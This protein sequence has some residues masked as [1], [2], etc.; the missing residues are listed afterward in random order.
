MGGGSRCGWAPAPLCSRFQRSVLDL[1][2]Q[3]RF[4]KLPNNAKLEVVPISRNRVGT[5]NRV[6]IALQLDSGSRLQDTFR[7][8]QT[9]WELLSHFTQTRE[10]VEQHGEFSPVCIYMRDEIAGKAALE[11]TTLKSLGLTGGNAIIRVVMKKCGSSGQ[12]AAVDTAAQFSKLPVSP[13]STEGAVDMSLPH[14]SMFSKD[15]D[16][17]DVA[18]SLN[19]CTD[20][21]DLIKVSQAS[22]GELW[23][24]SDPAPAPFVPF[25][26]DG[27]RLGGTPVAADFPV[28]DMLSSKLP[29]S[30]PSPGGPS[31][32]KKSKTS[33]EQLKEQE[34]L[35]EREPVVCHPDLEEPLSAGPQ[36][37]PDEFFE[38]TVDDVRKRLAQL[39]SERKRLEE[40]PFM[41]K[42]LREAQMKEKLE[43]YPKVVLRVQFPDRHVLQGFFRPNETV[44]ILRDFVRSHLADAELPFYLCES[45]GFLN[46]FLPLQA[47]PWSDGLVQSHLPSIPR[48]DTLILDPGRIVSPVH[49]SGVQS[50]VT[51]S[52]QTNFCS[53][54]VLLSGLELKH[55]WTVRVSLSLE[56]KQSAPKPAAC[57]SGLRALLIVIC[58]LTSVIAPPR[59]ILSNEN[60]TLFQANLFPASVIHFGSEENRDCYLRPELLESA[61]SPSTAD[62]LVARGLSKSIVPSAPP[63]SETAVPPPVGPEETDGKR[64]AENPEPTRA[65]EASQPVRSH[66]EKVPK[67]LKLPAG[68]R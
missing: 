35:L 17:R 48:G 39:Q 66:P 55:V 57:C 6:Q 43:R 8:G 49:D 33:R 44:G 28:S 64:T 37:L 12:E 50:V 25:F 54:T 51:C 21:Q 59:A 65:N 40:A 5:E 45:S 30:L 38:V 14:A 27:Q 16:P 32:P 62:L 20:K 22:L 13:V 4:A 23:P 63:V 46:P 34:Q 15:L 9:L 42:S 47:F 56:W 1:S 52:P 18:F 53:H 11:R 36:D 68:K 2:L 7:S 31:K 67:W 60:E 3:W 19:I 41:T 24:P 26:G 29:T 10:C 61:V 58:S